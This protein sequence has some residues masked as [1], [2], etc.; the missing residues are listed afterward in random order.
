MADLPS[1]PKDQ[2]LEDLV[3]A[4][5]VSRGCFV[6][7][8]VTERLPKDV[9]D[10]DVLWTDYREQS[11]KPR[12]VEVKSGEWGLGD[13][14]KFYGWT[15]YLGLSPGQ[16]AYAEDPS[17][18]ALAATVC[19]R[20]GIQLLRVREPADVATAFASLGLP[21]PAAAY[22]P[23]LWRFSYWARRRF[24]EALQQAIVQGVCPKA[25]IEAK[26]Y[27]K[28]INDALFFE[29]DP[30]ERFTR[31]LEAHL[32]HRKLASTAAAE[33]EGH[34]A[35]FENPARVETFKQALYYGRHLPVQ[36][37]MYL[38]HRA[39]L[40]VLK[41]AVDCALARRAGT[42]P[43]RFLRIGE[44]KWDISDTALTASFSKATDEFS[45]YDWFPLLP[46]FWQVFLWGWGGFLLSDRL[47]REYQAL[48]AQTGVPAEA[49]PKALEAFDHFFPLG[50]DSWLKSVSTASRKVLQQMPPA[51]RGIGAYHRLRL[52]GI[53][54]YRDL[55]YVDRTSG[56]LADDHNT[57]VRLLES[58]KKDL[59]R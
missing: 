34:G 8:R 54:E 32:R 39:R 51:L 28:L 41:T 7:T 10:I 52:Y 18:A 6:D 48:A 53:K 42:L 43:K 37:C 26:E 1:R 55:G 13:L 17:D 47:E 19:E 4:H 20:T 2:D 24:F 56:H 22:L 14:F 3:A 21:E 12:P 44:D 57:V 59:V 49:V 31:L 5:F 16:F 27:R 40:Y 38:T 45:K 50:G 46:T 15:R 33:T 29:Q 9:S 30:R 23:K 58:E 35:D 36:A 25:A 11:P